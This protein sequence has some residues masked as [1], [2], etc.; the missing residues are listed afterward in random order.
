MGTILGSRPRLAGTRSNAAS[1][2][3]V[4]GG[5]EASCP[6]MP[7]APPTPTT[8]GVSFPRLLPSS[9]LPRPAPPPP[10]SSLGALTPQGLEHT[11]PVH[12]GLF[13][14]LLF[15]WEPEHWLL[16]PSRSLL[17]VT[18]SEKPSLTVPYTM[19]KWIRMSLP[20]P[21]RLSGQALGVA[22]LA[23]CPGDRELCEAGDP[24]LAQECMPS[25]QHTHSSCLTNRLFMAVS[26][27]LE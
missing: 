6:G 12:L 16:T 8:P 9:P 25:A 5:P 20:L 7:T 14:A 18:A 10:R 15:P 11:K 26:Q 21:S 13:P 24:V 27:G 23:P 22:H 19:G 17:H 1:Q 4:E 2:T 3:R